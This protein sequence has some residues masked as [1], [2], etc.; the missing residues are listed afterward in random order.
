[1]TWM[2][3]ALFVPVPADADQRRQYNANQQA[4]E[5]PAQRHSGRCCDQ[6]Q[7]SSSTSTG[8]QSHKDRVTSVGPGSCRG[9]RGSGRSRSRYVPVAVAVG[10]HVRAVIG[11][12]PCLT[13]AVSTRRPTIEPAFRPEGRNQQKMAKTSAAKCSNRIDRQ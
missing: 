4:A 6:R 7:S 12:V 9:R 5:I 8:R 2:T 11:R 3:P 13:S 1:M 10:S